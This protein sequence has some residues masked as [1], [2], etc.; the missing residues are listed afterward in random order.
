MRTDT[1]EISTSVSPITI[2]ANLWQP[3]ILFAVQMVWDELDHCM[4]E[5]HSTSVE[6]SKNVICE[7]LQEF[8]PW[9]YLK[10]LSEKVSVVQNYLI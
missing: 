6:K 10:N 2:T 5:K 7:L 9:H 4:K 8:F 3:P 1:L